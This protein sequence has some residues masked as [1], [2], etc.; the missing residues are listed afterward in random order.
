MS[1]GHAYLPIGAQNMRSSTP[2]AL[3]IFSMC[4]RL[5]SC[6]PLSQW[7]TADRW[8]PISA[9]NPAGVKPARRRQCFTRLATSV[10]LLTS[11]TLRYSQREVK[12]VEVRS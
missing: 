4:S 8:T 10:P 5:G 7:E 9:A 12:R 11:P 1:S 6:L 3:A 2:H